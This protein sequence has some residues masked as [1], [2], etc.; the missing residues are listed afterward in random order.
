MDDVTNTAVGFLTAMQEAL[1]W[2]VTCIDGIPWCRFGGSTVMTFPLSEHYHVGRSHVDRVLRESRALLAQFP[3]PAPTGTYATEY[4]LRDKGYCETALQRQ[5]RQMLQR[6]ERQLTFRELS[7]HECA[8]AGP[9]VLRAFRGRQGITAPVAEGSWRD[10]CERGASS[11][12]FVVFGCHHGDVL[13]G[14]A[15]LWRRP[16]GYRTV[17]IAV[18]PAFF[19]MG[20]ANL[21]LYRTARDLIAR[22]DCEF[23]S[24]GRSGIPEIEGNSR[25]K[26]HAGLREEPLRMAAILHPR[27]RWLR[28]VGSFAPSPAAARSAPGPDSRI[29]RHLEALAAAAATNPGH[30][31]G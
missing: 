26:R 24:F 15:I 13:A 2:R 6:G 9:R 3:T 27:I 23:V 8:A 18:D 17:G 4:V 21:L 28:H 20:A 16:L 31:P 1:G 19:P 7:W 12:A 14:F 22:S 29:A 10:A 5:F 30:L 11:A 25:F